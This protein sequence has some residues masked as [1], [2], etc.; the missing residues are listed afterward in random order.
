[1]N[2]VK[3][4]P[5]ED[6]KAVER[7]QNHH[8]HETPS[9]SPEPETE[10]SRNSP[11]RNSKKPDFMNHGKLGGLAECSEE[12]FID[13]LT[14]EH[15]GLHPAM[16]AP[17]PPP[18]FFDDDFET[19]MILFFAHPENSND[20]IS[21]AACFLLLSGTTAMLLQ[22]LLHFLFATLFP[23]LVHRPSLVKFFLPFCHQFCHNT[24]PPLKITHSVKLSNS[25][26]WHQTS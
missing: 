11:E 16:L 25:S 6:W 17:V 2:D 9:P 21:T 13:D 20:I 3:M 10:C 26:S 15:I 18:H 7:R 19:V 14:I 12:N 5:E 24:P 8:K 23:C 22:P 1:M 4:K